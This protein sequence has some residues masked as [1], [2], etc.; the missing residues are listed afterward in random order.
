MCIID[1]VLQL[2][3]AAGKQGEKTI[4][5]AL[6]IGGDLR[7]VVT[8][9]ECHVRTVG[10]NQGYWGDLRT[11]SWDLVKLWILYAYD[12]YYFSTNK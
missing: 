1:G 8:A 10:V 7:L 6:F 2:N 4:R 9:D 11:W 12:D 5:P 3:S